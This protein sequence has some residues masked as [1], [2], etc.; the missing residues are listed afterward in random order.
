MNDRTLLEICVIVQK[1]VKKYGLDTLKAK[2]LKC[3]N[4][5][6]YDYDKYHLGL[7]SL[8][9]EMCDYG[10]LTWGERCKFLEFMK[11]DFENGHWFFEY[12]GKRTKE[13]AQFIWFP[14]DVEQRLAWINEQIKI[15]SKI[16]KDSK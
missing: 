10:D 2:I 9:D 3:E 1:Q 8:V 6:F 5:Q 13:N 16:Y 15:L 11:H 14:S 7:C 12:D 4:N